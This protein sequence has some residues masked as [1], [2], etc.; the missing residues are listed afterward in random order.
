[1]DSYA[2]NATWINILRGLSIDSTEWEKQ[3]IEKRIV[4]YRDV[5]CVCISTYL[6]I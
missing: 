4:V 2:A 3:D 1:M 6:N 5:S